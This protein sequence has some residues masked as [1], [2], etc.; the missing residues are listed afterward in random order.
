MSDDARLTKPWVAPIQSAMEKEEWR[1]C[2]N[3]HL[4]ASEEVKFV[5]V[6]DLNVSE[7]SVKCSKR[8]RGDADV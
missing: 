1:L 4:F 2:V 7:T 8:S 5:K 3:K 6:K